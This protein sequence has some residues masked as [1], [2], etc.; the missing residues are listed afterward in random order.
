MD[1]GT[2]LVGAL[3]SGRSGVQ[4]HRPRGGRGGVERGE[5]VGRLTGV[6][7]AMWLPGVEAFR[8]WSGGGGAQWGG[9][10]ARERRRGELGEGWDVL[11]V[12][13]EG[14]F[15]GAG[16]EGRSTG[17][18]AALMALIPLKAGARLRGGRIKGE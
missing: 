2:E 1:G 10:P 15:I 13:E 9:A 18:T 8:W 6:H 17:V 3:A 5:L 12:L 11:G 16:V 7:A 14:A 4:G